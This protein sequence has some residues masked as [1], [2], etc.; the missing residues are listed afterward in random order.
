M[1]AI[2]ERINYCVNQ[3]NILKLFQ[4]DGEFPLGNNATERALRCI[5][6][7]EKLTVSIMQNTVHYLDH[8][9]TVPKDHQDDMDY[10]FMDEPLS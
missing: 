9:L 7:H 4:N 6:M 8:V 1:T 5:N 2:L 3:E 10:S